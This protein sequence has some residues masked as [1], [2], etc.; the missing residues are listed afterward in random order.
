[1][2]DLST[3]APT[4]AELERVKGKVAESL[5]KESGDFE[6]TARHWL[7]AHTH[8]MASSSSAE[9][10]RAVNALTPSEVQ[11]VAA[12][13][14]LNT[15]VAAVVVGDASKLREELARAGG[16]EVFGEAVL[17]PEPAPPVRPAPTQTPPLRLKRP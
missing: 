11:R 14:F 9:L 4:A 5:V 15:P 12:R 8:D 16:V 10:L 2:R 6:A 3:N 1:L 7:D 13:L 17:K